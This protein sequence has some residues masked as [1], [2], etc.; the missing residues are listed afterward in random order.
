MWPCALN[1]HLHLTTFL[2]DSH[3]AEYTRK[4]NLQKTKVNTTRFVQ[5]E[6]NFVLEK[7]RGH[8]PSSQ[9]RQYV[10]CCCQAFW[11]AGKILAVYNFLKF[12]NCNSK[13]HLGCLNRFTVLIASYQ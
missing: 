7:A 11:Q 4:V 10:D 8:M 13:A 6:I 9:V 3:H 5:M 1:Y 12:N 2:N